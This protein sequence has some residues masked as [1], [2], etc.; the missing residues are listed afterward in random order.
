MVAGGEGREGA[1][2]GATQP[3]TKGWGGWAIMLTRKPVA[4]SVS[5][6]AWNW[7]GSFMSRPSGM[8]WSVLKLSS[9]MPIG[10]V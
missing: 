4:G 9:M 2:V 5:M 3:P 6:K 8:G 7:V 1:S 10:L